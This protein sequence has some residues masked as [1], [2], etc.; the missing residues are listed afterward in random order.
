MLGS[1]SSCWDWM[2]D[3]CYCY[4]SHAE[5]SLKAKLRDKYCCQYAYEGTSLTVTKSQAGQVYLLILNATVIIQQ[6]IWPV[7]SISH[8]CK[9]TSMICVSVF[10]SHRTLTFITINIFRENS[11]SELYEEAKF[12]KAFT[13]TLQKSFL[14]SAYVDLNS[15]SW[16]LVSPLFCISV[17]PLLLGF[18]LFFEQLILSV[19]N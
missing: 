4:T 19:G 1:L 16:V 11:N 3:G 10:H 2:K 6:G 12:R 5:T 15:F 8:L 14:Y 18:D 9:F 13:T 17:F 7:V